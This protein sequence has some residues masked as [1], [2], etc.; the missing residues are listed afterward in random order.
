[1][2]VKDE[3]KEY[4][5]YAQDVLSGNIV[6]GH[7]IKLSCERFISWYSRDDIEFRYE[8]VDKMIRFVQRIKFKKGLLAGQHFILL[9]FQQFIIAN[10]FG[11]YY[12]NSD[13]RVI[14]NVLL[15]M[16]R[17]TGKSYT[18]AAISLCIALVDDVPA[19]NVDY[20][21]N[22]GKQAQLAF[23]HCKDQADSLDP[24]HLIFKTYRSSIRIPKT[25]ANINVLSSDTSR[26]DGRASYFISDEIHENKNF[27]I[28]NIL[29]TGQG[30]LKNPLAIGIST[31]GFHLGDQ[32]PL[33]SFWKLNKNIL[34]GNI[35]D[36]SWFSAIFQLDEDDD[37]KEEKNWIKAIPSLGSAVD[38]EYIRKQIKT[39]IDNPANE[40]SIKTKNLNMWVQSSETW[41]ASEKINDI[42]HH[43]DLTKFDQETSYAIIGADI[44]ERSD[45]CCLGGLIDDG[46]GKL[47]FKIWPFICRTGLTQSQNKEIYAAWIKQGH[48]IYIDEDSIDIDWV[49]KKIMD[50]DKEINIG[51]VAYDPWHAKQLCIKCAKEGIPMKPVSQSI[52]SFGEPTSEFQQ[53]IVSGK[54]IVLDDNPIIKWAFNNVLIKRD[55]NENCKPVKSSPYAK[56]D[57]IICFIQAMKLWMDL[58][59]LSTDTE[60]VVLNDK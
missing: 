56:I 1:M 2:T 42:T 36:D 13:R 51:I 18:A 21:A 12:V 47:Y 59:G 54:T 15:M 9:P 26:L 40:V 11:W 3:T 48:L 44:A 38:L 50:I 30:S 41:I 24:M 34:E 55:E 23:N 57:P 35:E 7:L 27:E 28:W 58:N 8:L 19:P 14:N 25:G 43:V 33:Y 29:K 60:V 31:C 52:G 20:I 6:A 5:K 32:Y 46:S 16:A 39:A 10:I 53:R 17:Q 37:W 22:S 45:L 49:V 4:I